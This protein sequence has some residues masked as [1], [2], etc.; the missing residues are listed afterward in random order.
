M[1]SHPYATILENFLTLKALC[2]SQSVGADEEKV[3]LIFNAIRDF[4]KGPY[5]S[6]PGVDSH[7]YNYHVDIGVSLMKIASKLVCN[8][9]INLNAYKQYSYEFNF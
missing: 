7:E 2:A 4:V 3:N 6:L 8:V 5:D 1:L 9:R